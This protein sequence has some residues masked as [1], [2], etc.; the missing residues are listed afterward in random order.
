MADSCYLALETVHEEARTRLVVATRQDPTRMPSQHAHVTF[1]QEIP[2]SASCIQACLVCFY[3]HCNALSFYH[4]VLSP[5]TS[6]LLYTLLRSMQS[7]SF[8]SYAYAKNCR[9]DILPQS[10]QNGSSRCAHFSVSSADIVPQQYSRQPSKSIH[11]LVMA[12]LVHCARYEN[13]N[14]VCESE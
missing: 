14:N 7:V 12:C 4:D 5:S 3:I 9:L 10:L 11:L 2:Q 8:R 1:E 13:L 6:K